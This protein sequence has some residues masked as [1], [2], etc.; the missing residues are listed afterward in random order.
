MEAETPHPGGVYKLGEFEGPLDLLLFLIRKAEVNI[1]DIPIAEI[2]D[3]YLAYL[4]YQTTLDLEDLSEFH[5][6]AATLLYIK[7]RM[8]LPVD[9]DFDEEFEDPRKELVDKL[10]E[11]QKFRKY[12]DLMAEKEKESEWD[13]SRAKKQRT[14]PF[15]DDDDLW[16][17]IDV[18]DL[19]QTFSR[20]VSSLSSERIIDLYEEVTINE[21]ITLLR[22]L[23]EERE[24]ISFNDLI[25]KSGSI[26]EIVCSFFALLEA[27]KSRLIVLMQNKLF[28]D[29]R[30][31]RRERSA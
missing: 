19:V 27:V 25:C 7:S 18:W 28:G 4:A 3:Q 15:P 20:I 30:I 14:L 12:T 16:E 8:L 2:T 17:Q 13:I 6:M 24:E 31:K 26:M 10:I 1:Y 22:E 21:K 23:L 29:I 11:Y 9:V 5:L